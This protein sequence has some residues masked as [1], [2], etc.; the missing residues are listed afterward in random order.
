MPLFVV[1]FQLCPR[2]NLS[3]TKKAWQPIS[4]CTV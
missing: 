3:L 4:V 2:E 1:P